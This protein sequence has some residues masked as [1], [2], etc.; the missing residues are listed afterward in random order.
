MIKTKEML[1]FKENK[2]KQPCAVI[3][4]STIDIKVAS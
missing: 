2:I 1:I 4:I 3:R